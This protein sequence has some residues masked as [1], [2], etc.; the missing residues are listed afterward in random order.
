M[1][2]L[3]NNEAVHH[4]LDP[5]GHYRDQLRLRLF[6]DPEQRP[7]QNHAVSGDH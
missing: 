1:I 2:E 3:T 4:H 7:V 5:P 6:P